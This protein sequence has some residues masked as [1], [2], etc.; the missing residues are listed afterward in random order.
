MNEIR[1]ANHAILAAVLAQEPPP[2][3][4]WAL[5]RLRVEFGKAIED[6]PDCP[7]YNFMSFAPVSPDNPYDIIGTIAG[8]K[9]TPY[10]EGTFQIRIG[11]TEHYPKLPPECTF[12]TRIWHP[13][14]NS[15]GKICLN[16]LQDEWSMA[17]SVR[18]ILLSISSLLSDPGLG[19]VEV[20]F[21]CVLM[22]EAGEMWM[23]DRG[24]FEE[25]ARDWTGKYAVPVED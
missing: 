23:V 3:H 15:Q 17:L 19:V 1:K 4:F 12:M 8:P 14:I 7:E 21:K 18:T 13:N 25:M 16:I 24:T 20:G 11:I 9:D 10:E 5:R 2:R 22:P 6:G